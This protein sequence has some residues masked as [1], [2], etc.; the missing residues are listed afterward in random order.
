MKSILSCLLITLLASAGISMAAPTAFF[1]Q[2]VASG[3]PRSS[4]VVLWTR[5][6][7]VDTSVNRSV[8]LHL[9]TA[10]SVAMVGS[11]A[12]LGGSNLYVGGTLTAEAAHDGIVKLKLTG[13]AADTEYYY[14]F[15]YNGNRSA[16]GRTKTAPGTASTRTVCYAAVNCNDFVGRY[17][18][19]LKHLCDQEADKIDF[20][21]N[22]GDYIYETTGD[23]SFQTTNP[24]RAMVFSAPAEAI[25][26]GGGNY[27]AQSLGNYRDIYKTIRQDMQLMRA[28]E[29]FPWISIWDD[30]EFSDDNW[31]DRAT[32]FDGKVNEQQTTRKRNGET[33]W[34]EFLPTERGLHVGGTG[35]DINAGN[36]YPNTVIYDSF[37]FGNNLDL[38]LTDNR[39]NRVDHLIPEDVCP[40]GVPM[41]ENDVIATLAAANGLDVPTFTAFVWPG[42]RTNF[43]PYV[44][45]DA[46]ANAT[47]K[48]TFKAII[49]QAVTSA[50]STLPA[51]QT[52]AWTGTSY[53]DAN[54]VGFRDAVFVNQVFASAGQPQPFDAAAINAMPRGLSYYLMGKTS[55]FSDFGSRYQLVNE[56]FQ[57][58]AGFTYQQF[59]LSG[60]VI[61]RDQAF[62]NSAQQTFL[63]TALATSS[64]ANRIWRV[65]ASSAPF[66]PIKLELG[67]LPAGV[68]LPTQGTISGVT[69]P[70]S[71]PSQF[72]V[73]FLL[74]GDEAAGFP[75]FRQGII[76]LLSQHDALLVSGDIHASL[77]GNNNAA[78]G[79]HVVDFTVPS[80]ASSQFR[81]AINS[82]F[83][84]VEA[85][86]TPGVQQATGLQG[87]FT[88]D[89][90]QKNAV[91]AATDEIIKKNTSEMFDADT[92]AHGYTVFVA[93]PTELVADYRKISTDWIDDNLYSRTPRDLD[94]LFAREKYRVTKNAG[95]LAL[96][97]S[98]DF[99]LRILHGTDMEAG[100]PSIAD[101]PRFAAILDKLEDAK[102]AD[103]AVTIASGDT[104]I[105]GAFLSAGNDISTRAAL[106]SAVDFLYPGSG[107]ATDMRENPGRP[108]IMMLN[109]MGFDAACLGNHEFDLGPT[110]VANILNP[111]FGTTPPAQPVQLSHVRHIGTEFPY[112]A[113]NLSFAGD[114]GL[115][116]RFTSSILNVL[117]FRSM[118]PPASPT[119]PASAFTTI[120]GKKTL[121]QATIIERG[122][123]KIGVL[124]VVPPNLSAISSPGGVVVTGPTT[125]DMVALAA[126]LQPVVN[127]LKTA[128]CNIIILATQLQQITNEKALILEL[129]DV[130]VVVAGGSGTIQANASTVLKPGDVAAEPYPFVTTDKN[131]KTAYV[132]CTDGEYSYLG[133]LV[134][135]FNALGEITALSPESEVYA[136]L[137]TNVTNH[138]GSL[139]LAYGSGTRGGIVKTLADT[140]GTVITAK[141]S[142]IF[143]KTTVGLEGRRTL[144]RQQET[145]LANI[146]SDA[147]LYVARQIDPT[148]SVS[149]KNGGGI[150]NLIGVVDASGVLPPVANP[151]SGKL[152][153]QISQ[154]DI[155]DSLK[156]NNLLSAQTVTAQQLRLIIEHGVAASN[157]V[158][159][160][161][162]TPGQF[163]Q[164]GGV[165]MAID[166]TATAQTYNRTGNTINSINEGQR[167]KFLAVVNPVTGAPADVIVL[168]GTVIGDPARPVRLVTLNFL[169]NSSPAGSDSGGDSY[170]FPYFRRI[171]G[172]TFSNFA[173]T[174]TAGTPRAGMALFADNN[175]EQ[176]AFAEYLAANFNVTPYGQADTSVEQDTRIVQGWAGLLADTDLDQLNAAIERALRTNAALRDTDGDGAPD[177]YEL[178]KFLNP[179]VSNPALAAAYLA[180]PV[181]MIQFANEFPVTGTV[182]PGVP[183]NIEYSTNLVNW[184]PVV[185]GPFTFGTSSAAVPVTLPPGLPG[186]AFFHYIPV[187][188]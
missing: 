39:T 100:V 76:D 159:S 48:A 23:P 78:G 164:V 68:T 182:T 111:I 115:N 173:S 136:A 9:T 146:S 62:Y 102:G 109:C 178:R 28:H 156:F 183:Y 141:D 63:G 99:T 10:G 91:I 133:N 162:A 51:G 155:E 149:I 176:D 30:H 21:L 171:N 1:P 12:A 53:A 24:A 83:A 172:A 47:I 110:E 11:T 6:V 20:I 37:N 42:L 117:D 18:N 22:L 179:L 81:R 92:D 17:Y 45:I 137:D 77:I 98:T 170:P 34:M 43:A 40:S 67:D 132:V 61:G 74:N 54:V 64:A 93:S 85:L 128:G 72:L 158:G 143:G 139:A 57:I 167:V 113:A 119:P 3:D 126:H 180:D 86:M 32:Y 114:S 187:T 169:A 152:A 59:V 49:S 123:R 144:V 55:L 140:I 8:S 103:A 46:P 160:A 36:L 127:S 88:F 15:T 16:I 186:R 69:I 90:A 101:A 50:L 79:Q 97:Q 129:E 163:C 14:Q 75:Q 26:L 157:G 168:N 120:N 84:S 4:S 60:G 161:Q 56:T 122:G 181:G 95:D 108:D 131:G 150:R 116:A 73:E 104:W 188:P 35:L 66:T 134:V 166:L 174:I 185:G 153:G 142:N 80:A 33:A 31:K 94:R 65:V 44:D 7:D 154:L 148:V 125:Y 71:I 19:V 87:N 177:G 89:T 145:N 135:N 2:S 25:D 118:L 147:N 130:D 151:L 58:F 5:V 29:L 38:I 41:T 70:A 124:G 82:A 175:S 165:I 184:F 138:W 52:P 112:L 121:A 27:A 105:P 106:K 96:A 107:N 13:L